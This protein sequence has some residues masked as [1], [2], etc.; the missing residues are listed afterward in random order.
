MG[1]VCSAT[2]VV[3]WS[4]DTKQWWAAASLLSIVSKFDIAFFGVFGKF[5]ILGEFRVEI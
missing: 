3:Q 1:G 5:G 4:R 2:P